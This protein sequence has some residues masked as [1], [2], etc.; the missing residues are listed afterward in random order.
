MFVIEKKQRGDI[1]CRPIHKDMRLIWVGIEAILGKK[2]TSER[3]QHIT[4]NKGIMNIWWEKVAE[5]TR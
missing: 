1:K 4:I 3:S 2:K 5:L